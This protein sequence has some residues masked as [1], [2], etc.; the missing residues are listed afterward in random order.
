MRT[1][2]KFYINGQWV[3]PI[4]KGTSEVINPANGEVSAV[5]PYGNSEDVDAAVSA[6]RNAFDSWSQT[7]AAVRADFLRKLAAEGERRNADL[8][9]TIIDELGMPI[10]NAAS[11]QVDPLA[12]I[13]ES[14]AE[15]ARQMEEHKEVGNSVVIKEA[16]GVC[17]MINPW[18]Y[19]IWQMIGK[20]APAIAAGCTMVV[21]AASQTPSHLFIFAE[22]CDAVGLPAGVFNIVHGS[23]R[24][25]G[26][27]L[28]SHPDIDM[29]TFT[30]STAAG[31]Q[32]S[33][34]AAPSV[35][36]V[37]LELGGKSPFIITEEADLEAAIGFG[38]N[39]V[40]VN[41]GQT[42]NALTRMIVHESVYEQA[43]DLAKSKA[44]ALVVGDPNDPGVFIGPMAS[45]GQ[46]QTVIDYINQAVSDG[47]RLVTGGAEPP[48][49][50]TLGNYVVPT[51]FADV[52]NDMTIAQEEVF[53][54][55]L[56]MIKYSTI[57]QAVEIANDTP[58]GLASA[59]WAQDKDKA[60]AIARR[61][62]A[63]QCA[64]NG[65]D[66]NHEAPFGGYK[67]SG[68]GRE[69]GAEGLHEYCELKAMQY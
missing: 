65:G 62:R 11:F 36:R 43:V 39:D 51:I 3:E 40:M 19:P 44:E 41:T 34:K 33:N 68:N 61:I 56:V 8:T 31:I 18:N 48:K 4:G 47:A 28:S 22:I 15:K 59:V 66:A 57:D 16:I 45:S 13:C 30:G 63:G 1:Y 35:K 50:L 21:K 27:A 32:V 37:C 58:Y 20:V 25:V 6:A 23:G 9:Q 42:C 12:I 2:S 60:T 26:A 46:K 49:G 17:S 54:P 38:V 64:I 55:V 5:V 29:V 10:Q 7:S 69:F 53:G 14:F 52:T 67:K 24:E